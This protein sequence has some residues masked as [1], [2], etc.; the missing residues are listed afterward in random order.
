MRTCLDRNFPQRESP[1]WRTQQGVVM[2][3]LTPE[4][5]AS[6]RA[7]RLHAFE[8]DAAR[9]R[10][11]LCRQEKGYTDEQWRWRCTPDQNRRVFGL[12]DGEALVG[13]TAVGRWNSEQSGRIGHFWGSY[14]HPGYRGRGLGALLYK[15]RVDWAIRNSIYSLAIVSYRK[16]VGASGELNQRC[17]AQLWRVEPALFANG[18]VGTLAWCW[19]P[20]SEGEGR[21]PL[22]P[23]L[24]QTA[25]LA[26]GP[27]GAS[28]VVQT[29]A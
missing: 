27:G 28:P 25:A 26:Q 17:G 19:I 18:Q 23:Y 29:A 21:S 15:A 7:L 4:D 9:Y 2:R 12:F 13:T 1:P 10:E 20:L 11:V 5:A 8:E 22:A 14:V 24:I 16:D 6:F 3:G